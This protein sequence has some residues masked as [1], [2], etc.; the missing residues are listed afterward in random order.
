MEEL[1]RKHEENRGTK[2]EEIERK[3]QTMRRDE[4]DTLPN[5][6]ECE[7]ETSDLIPKYRLFKQKSRFEKGYYKVLTISPIFLGGSDN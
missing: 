4:E 3:V 5:V 1:E 7:K 2:I 6:M